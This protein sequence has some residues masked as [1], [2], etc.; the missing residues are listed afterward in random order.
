MFS[1]SHAR[2]VPR[3]RNCGGVSSVV[4]RAPRPCESCNRHTGETPVP[5]PPLHFLLRGLVC[6]LPGTF[7]GMWGLCRPTA[8]KKGFSC[9]FCMQVIVP[10][11]SATIRFMI[12]F[13]GAAD[14]VTC[15]A[16]RGRQRQ[17]FRDDRAPV[18]LIVVNP[19]QPG[20][21]ARGESATRTAGPLKFAR[22]SSEAVRT[23]R[24][25]GLKR[26]SEALSPC[27]SGSL[28]GWPVREF[29]RRNSAVEAE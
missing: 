1:H 28:S 3:Q 18:V 11:A 23:R 7:Q 19:L 17:I 29:Q 9:F 8:R 21:A 22:C 24:P 25:S 14:E 12:N 13:A 4:A 15:F 5:L 26:A 20:P 2:H 10:L 6:V 16:E 27:A